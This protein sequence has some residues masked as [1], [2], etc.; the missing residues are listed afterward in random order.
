MCY[1]LDHSGSYFVSDTFHHHKNRTHLS[2][3]TMSCR[4]LPFA[5]LGCIRITTVTLDQKAVN[6]ALP[7]GLCVVDFGVIS[8]YFR[9]W[10][11]EDPVSISLTYIRCVNIY[12]V[13]API[14]KTNIFILGNCLIHT[15]LVL[16][17]SQYKYVS[18]KMT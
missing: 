15:L 1:P 9:Q 13:R 16:V 2:M 5:Q 11:C 17:E 4:L 12:P 6:K 7:L 14:I 10:I 8:D 18:G 3:I